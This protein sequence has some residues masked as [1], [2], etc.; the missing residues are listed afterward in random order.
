MNLDLD[1][2]SIA[3]SHEKAQINQ[4]QIKETKTIN[5]NS[6]ITLKHSTKT[7]HKI[8]EHQIETI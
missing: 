2:H 5:V 1:D 4:K 6:A 3:A 8:R 7:Q